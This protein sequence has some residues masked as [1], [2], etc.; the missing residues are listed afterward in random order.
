M[1]HEPKDRAKNK[2]GKERG[3]QNLDRT[4]LEDELTNRSQAKVDHKLTEIVGK[5]QPLWG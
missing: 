3:N 5:E 1:G 4:D 2:A